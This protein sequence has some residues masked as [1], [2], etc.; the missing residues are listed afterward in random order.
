LVSEGGWGEAQ[1]SNVA[2][3]ADVATG[4]VYRYRDAIS[5]QI[6]RIVKAAQDS[7]FAVERRFLGT[8]RSTPT[9]GSRPGATDRR[10]LPLCDR[11]G[12]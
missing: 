12:R 7:N 9:D 6:M 10:C 5:K 1:I 11:T 2:S 4:S 3:S 8:W